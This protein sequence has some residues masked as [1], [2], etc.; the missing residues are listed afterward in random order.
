MCASTFCLMA[1]TIIKTNSYYWCLC[2]LLQVGVAIGCATRD[3][4]VSFASTF[5]AF[6]SRAYDHI[7]MGAVSQSNVNLVGSHCGVSIGK[8]FASASLVFYRAE[9]VCLA[10][11][12]L[13][14]AFRWGWSFPDGLRGLGHVPCYPNMHCILPQWRSVHRKSCWAFSQHKGW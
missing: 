4:A 8:L 10:T 6:F 9:G 13:C 5:S 7:R 2:L 12:W 1:S 11:V 3:R 14:S